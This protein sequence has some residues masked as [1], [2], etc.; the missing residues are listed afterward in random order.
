[1]ST[2]WIF[3]IIDEFNTGKTIENSVT[4]NKPI[5]VIFNIVFHSGIVR[6]K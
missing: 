4:H 5:I 1:M 2:L 6:K 3:G